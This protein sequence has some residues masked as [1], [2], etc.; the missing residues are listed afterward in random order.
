MKNEIGFLYCFH[1]D[2]SQKTMKL[3]ITASIVVKKMY[4][5]V[6]LVV[7]LTLVPS[8]PRISKDWAQSCM[9]RRRPTM[10][11]IATRKLKSFQSAKYKLYFSTNF[12]LISSVEIFSCRM[13]LLS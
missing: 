11:R 9:P 3:A 4:H 13:K 5:V 6:R 10:A 2:L 1:T 7:F 8:S 12:N